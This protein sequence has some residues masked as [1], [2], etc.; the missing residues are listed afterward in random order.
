MFEKIVAVTIFFWLGTKQGNSEL[1]SGSCISHSELTLELTRNSTP[2][3]DSGAVQWKR[4][5]P[6][7]WALQARRPRAQAYGPCPCSVFDVRL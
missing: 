1:F 5:I 6:I 3:L 7:K 4:A 2:A